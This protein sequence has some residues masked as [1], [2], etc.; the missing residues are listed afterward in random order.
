MFD[1]QAIKTSN[2][3]FF[4]SA[5][6]FLFSNL[7][8]VCS[9]IYNCVH[10]YIIIHFPHCRFVVSFAQSLISGLTN[11]APLIVSKFLE[12]RPS[13]YLISE[14]SA[15]VQSTSSICLS[16]NWSLITLTSGTHF[17]KASFISHFHYSLFQQ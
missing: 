3:H 2:I 5:T 1:L 12:A 13:S 4:D 15:S 17:S 7:G 16:F 10:I 9:K 8:S 11:F 14:V 6:Y